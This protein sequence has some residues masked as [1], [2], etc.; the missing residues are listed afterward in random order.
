MLEFL[1]CVVSKKEDRISSAQ[2]FCDDS[3]AL[4]MVLGIQPKQ[5]SNLLFIENGI[6]IVF[7]NEEIVF[8][9]KS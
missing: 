4:L 3:R 6:R 1:S 9:V 2:T 8:A 7:T 5:M